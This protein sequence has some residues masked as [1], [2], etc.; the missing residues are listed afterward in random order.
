MCWERGRSEEAR[1]LRNGLTWVAC[2][3]SGAMVMFEPRLL[4]RALSWSMAMEIYVDVCGSCYHRR[5]RRCPSSGRL[6]RD[7]L[8]LEGHPATGAMPIWV[9]YNAS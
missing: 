5:P 2:L 4:P 1:L 8:A 7:M 3:S 6:S 9:T